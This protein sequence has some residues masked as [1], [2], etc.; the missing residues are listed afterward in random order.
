MHVFGT[1]LF[2][3]YVLFG[4]HWDVLVVA[5]TNSVRLLVLK[6]SQRAIH[7]LNYGSCGYRLDFISGD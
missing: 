7:F 1:V 2:E 4:R 6:V 5:Y 3:P